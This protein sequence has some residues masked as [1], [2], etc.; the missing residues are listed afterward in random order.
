MRDLF[1]YLLR[2]EIH[3]CKGYPEVR[4]IA[5]TLVIFS[6]PVLP[7]FGDLEHQLL[8]HGSL[9]LRKNLVIKSA[10]VLTVLLVHF[11]SCQGSDFYCLC[12]VSQSSE[13]LALLKPSYSKHVV[14]QTLE[15]FHSQ[16]VLAVLLHFYYFCRFFT[17]LVEEDF[18]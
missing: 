5:P 15:S 12:P 16:N 4:V 18:H 9:P 6:H 8:V 11:E 13:L 7:Y 2:V 1:G 3:L 14:L 17:R 10:L